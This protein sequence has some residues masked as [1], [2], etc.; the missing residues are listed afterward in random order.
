MALVLDVRRRG[1]VC[2]VRFDG[3]DELRCTRSFAQRTRIGRGQQIE[4]ALIERLRETA[5]V[6]LG[7]EL[8]RRRL[9]HGIHSRLELMQRLLGAGI[10]REAAESALDRLQQAG[11]LDDAAGALTLARISLRETNDDWVSFRSRCGRRLQR[12][13]FPGTAIARA[14]TRAWSEAEQGTAD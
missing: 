14:L 10:S 11:E 5:G 1:A 3:A 9:G 13:G 4:P 6:E 7:L 12:R 8:A 2:V